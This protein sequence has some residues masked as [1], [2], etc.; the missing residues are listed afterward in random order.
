[1]SVWGIHLLRKIA[2][3]PSGIV[4]GTLGFINHLRR[5]QGLPQFSSEAEAYA[6]GYINSNQYY[7]ALDAYNAARGLPP[8]Q[9][10][11]IDDAQLE[12]EDAT[13]A[14]ERYN[15]A[16][17]PATINT[18]TE[19]PRIQIPGLGPGS[20]VGLNGENLED[21]DIYEKPTPAASTAP[22]SPMNQYGTFARDR[23]RQSTLR[24]PNILDMARR[25]TQAM[26]Q[27][28]AA[29]KTGLQ[30]V[31][32]FNNRYGGSG[33]NQEEVSG[34]GQLPNPTVLDS[35]DPKLAPQIAAGKPVQAALSYGLGWVNDRYRQQQQ[36]NKQIIDKTVDAA[37][38]RTQSPDNMVPM[39]PVEEKPKSL[40][41][42]RQAVP[43]QLPWQQMIQQSQQ[44]VKT[45]VP[46]PMP[47]TAKTRVPLPVP[48][49][50]SKQQ[51]AQT[52]KG[53]RVDFQV[54]MDYYRTPSG[55]IAGFTAGGSAPKGWKPISMASERPQTATASAAKN[56][57]AVT[58]ADNTGTDSQG[59]RYYSFKP[60]N[61]PV[62]PT[63][64][65]PQQP[66]QQSQQATSPQQ[67]YDN[68]LKYYQA[69]GN[70]LAYNRLQNALKYKDR[71]EG[72]S[73]LDKVPDYTGRL[74]DKAGMAAD[75]AGNGLSRRWNA[76][77][78]NRKNMP[79]STDL[80]RIRQGVNQFQDNMS[81]HWNIGNPL[82]NAYSAENAEKTRA[83]AVSDYKTS[84]LPQQEKQEQAT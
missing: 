72:Q 60:D 69:T 74:N 84:I 46:L 22:T 23:S 33:L 83:N 44:P 39:Q 54:G 68:A 28:P 40:L 25:G 12:Q 63:A 6:S 78:A 56:P 55:G 14:V 59:R 58:A 61:T 36:Q 52:S 51:S 73:Y 38:R 64:S 62:A 11:G 43:Q 35:I 53:S 67:R 5:L 7:D 76:L 81:S 80:R 37:T 42:P 47:Q 13:A 20:R 29:I 2:A 32:N 49:P 57:D 82:H 31:Q 21:P 26:T 65:T 1:M 8:A 30:A 79:Q 48:T 9:R 77:P 17:N 10:P 45:S 15:R 19:R 24:R 27:A 34:A 71:P 4:S 66:A 41:P 70:K 3:G 75:A 16:N 50:T 18:V